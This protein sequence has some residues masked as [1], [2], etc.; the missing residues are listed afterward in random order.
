MVDEFF[1][2]HIVGCD[3]DRLDRVVLYEAAMYEKVVHLE[4]GGRVDIR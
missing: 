4:E 3:D 2:V 1:V